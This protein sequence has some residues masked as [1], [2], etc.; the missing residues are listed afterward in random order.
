MTLLM[1]FQPHYS[2]I[3]KIIS[4]LPLKSAGVKQIT[5]PF[6]TGNHTFINIMAARCYAY[7]CFSPVSRHGISVPFIITL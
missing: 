1:L 3:S 2:I 4:I 5:T 7:V 6:P